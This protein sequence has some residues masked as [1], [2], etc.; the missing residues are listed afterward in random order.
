MPKLTLGDLLN[1]VNPNTATTVAPITRPKPTLSNPR[2]KASETS[3]VVVDTPTPIDNL[4]PKEPKPMYNRFASYPFA[5]EFQRNLRKF[6]LWFGNPATGKTTLAKR[7]A[8]RLVESGDIKDYAVV[9]AHEDL[10]LMSLFKT[11]TTS[12]N[13]TWHFPFNRVFQMLTDE[14]QER[15]IIIFDEINTLMMSTMK[16]MQPTFDDTSGT[17]D[18]ED[19]TY[20]KNPNVFFIATMNHK[21][22]GT[23][24]LPDAIKSRAFPVFFKDLPFHEVAKRSD[25][26]VPFIDLLKRIYDMFKDM[27]QLHPFYNDVR[28]LKNIASLTPE[29]FKQYIISQLEFAHI[30]YESVIALSPEFDNLINEY[31]QIN[32][33]LR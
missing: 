25:V 31:S 21:D 17:F 22:L 20:T 19:K 16:G 8:Q 3:K 23:S 11:A 33:E 9:N 1:G 5:D 28:Q 18:F 30:E 27:G 7:V 13:G 4:L 29:A 26:P 2:K 24:P 6:E 12:D 15:Y 32:W 10:S 14:L